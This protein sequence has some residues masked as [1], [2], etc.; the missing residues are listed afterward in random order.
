MM[1]PRDSEPTIGQDAQHEIIL[2]CVESIQASINMYQKCGASLCASLEQAGCAYLE[3][4]T[5]ILSLLASCAAIGRSLEIVLAVQ[6]DI[7][8]QAVAHD[9]KAHLQANQRIWTAVHII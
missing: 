1:P 9:H 4:G 7:C 3:D 6:A 2:M 5:W 8:R